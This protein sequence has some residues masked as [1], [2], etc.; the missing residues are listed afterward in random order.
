[1]INILK[2]SLFPVFFSGILILMYLNKDPYLDFGVYSDY[3]WKYRFQQMGDLGTKKLLT[4]SKSSYNSFILGSSRTTGIYACYLEKINTNA[5]FFHYVNFNESIGGIYS[6]LY[7]LDSL[8]YSL[9]NIIIYLDTDTTFENYGEVNFADHFLLT[10]KTKFKSQIDHFKSFMILNTDK[11][12]ILFGNELIGESFPN[13][14]SDKITNDPNHICSDSIILSYNK[15][16]K[17]KDKKYLKSIDSLK[18]TGFMY[19][20]DKIQQYKENQISKVEFDLL[21]KIKVLLNKNKSNYYIIITPL[22]DQLKFSKLDNEK[23]NN[24]FKNR[25]YDFS[26]INKMTNNEYN[27]PDRSHFLPYISKKILDSIVLPNNSKPKL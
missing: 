15:N 6:K 12:N 24:V 8:G 14:I 13:W 27:Y 7:L 21:S 23:L 11:I 1:M 3:S 22:Y 17:L 25:I 4:K 2:F 20:R 5:K 16:E 18:R 9:D 26:G 19:K 10:N